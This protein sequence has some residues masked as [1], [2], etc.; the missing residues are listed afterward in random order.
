[1]LDVV[2]FG[3]VNVDLV[4]RLD[5]AE[6]KELSA[7]Y[8]WFPSPDETVAV[9]GVPSAVDEHVDRTLLGGKGANQAVAAARAGAAAGLCGR[10]GADET[11][12]LVSDTLAD[13]GVDTTHVEVADV[14]TGKAYVF[15]DDTGENRIA[16]L[17]GANGTVDE[18]YVRRHR[19][20]I[21]HADSLLLQNEIPMGTM[22]SLADSLAGEP[23][24]PTVIFDPAPPVDAGPLL[25]TGVVDIVTPN[26]YESEVL[27][28]AIEDFDGTVIRKRGA[29]DLLVE[30]GAGE[31]FEVS[32]PTVTPVDT[33]GAG[34]VFSGYLA[35]GLSAGNT[36]REAVA[37]AAAAASLSTTE[38]G[39]QRAIPSRRVVADFV[40]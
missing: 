7:R 1:M 10:V 38:E 15:V 20:A 11:E 33:T 19:E 16:I 24:R 32:P 30:T 9:P 40:G 35:A 3:S 27:G 4:A 31:S 26:A 23:D 39:A 21:L 25:R 14:E 17:A 6:I 22:E 36:L 5:G 34:D 2:S 37:V 29:E 12:H 28:A 8:D 13:R 18:S